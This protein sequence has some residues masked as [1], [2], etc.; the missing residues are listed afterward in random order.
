M[1]KKI[2]IF[3][4]LYSSLYAQTKMENRAELSYVNS[5]G[6]T[7][8]SSL[9]GSILTEVKFGEREVKAKANIFRSKDNNKKSANK[10]ELD[11]DYN[12][13]IGDRLYT[14]MGV[15]YIND[16][17]SDY[18]SRLN[19]GPGLGYKFIYTD[20]ELL[21]IQGGL[22]YAV[23]KFEDGS[24]DEYVAPR[25]ELNYKY[26]IKENIEFKQMLSYLVSME[27]SKKYFFTSETGVA[28][29]MV[30]NLSLGANYRL[31]Y[32]NQTEKKKLD[33]KFL[34]SLIYDF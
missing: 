5:S 32:V 18:D 4:L 6:N 21:D 15:Y 8:T 12:H 11:A 33:R 29:K 1:S 16:E 26:K 34:T 24:K 17:F 2:L 3:A 28:V 14:Y 25:T 23:D 20:D 13:M 10:Y 9:N 19:I 7:N 27:D 22:D 31:D 30:E